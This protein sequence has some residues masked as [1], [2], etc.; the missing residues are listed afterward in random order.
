MFYGFAIVRV[1]VFLY[2]ATKWKE[3]MVYWHR[4]ERPFLYEP[5]T[6][7]SFSLSLKLQLIGFVFLILCLTEHLMFIV[8]E[9]HD[10][11]YEL[12]YCNVTTV[13]FLN[14]YMRRE[15]PH[16]LL[17][18]PYRW[19]IFPFFQWSITL[20]AFGWNF[21]DYFIIVISIAL[22]T[23]FNQ[24][25]RR[26]RHTYASERDQEFWNEFRT[27]FCNLVD[28][29]RFIDGKIALLVL[30]TMIQNLFLICTKVFEAI[31]S[32]KRSFVIQSVYFYFYLFFLLFR[33][34]AL[35]YFCSSV[36]QEALHPLVTIRRTPTKHWNIGVSTDQP[37][38]LSHVLPLA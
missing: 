8:M 5:Y 30:L 37:T 10:N 1:Y 14:N 3:I 22:T 12:T 13:S 19:W 21:V 9:L 15:R 36:H 26:L 17:V 23:R 28:L 27:H 35:L 16:L 4:K 32:T 6:M 25:N 2:L 38:S 7:N 29:L 34:S 33:T 20:L 18:L 31:R 24:L 11:D